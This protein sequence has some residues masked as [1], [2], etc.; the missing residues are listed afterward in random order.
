MKTIDISTKKSSI[1]ELLNMAK[2]EPILV[3]TKDGDSFVISSTDEFNSEVELLRR[4]HKFLSM[5]DSF[6]GED[7]TFPIDLVEK[8]LR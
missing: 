2:E 1:N 5:L 6:K 4:N 3:T 8:T 7:E